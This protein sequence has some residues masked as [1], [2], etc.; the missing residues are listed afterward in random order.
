MWHIKKDTIERWCWCQPLTK[1]GCDKI[2]EV[3]KKLDLKPMAEPGTDAAKDRK[4]KY[5]VIPITDDTRWIFETCSKMVIDMNTQFFEYDLHYISELHFMAYEEK[6]D[7]YNKH[8]DVM[9]DSAGIR[10]LSFS[11]QLSDPETYKGGELL[12]HFDKD[13]VKGKSDQGAMTLYPSFSL[14]E[15]TP[16]VKGV[17]YVLVGW[18]VGPKLK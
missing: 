3:G 15:T 17:S 7:V 5:A 11:I 12:L 1:E 6:G 8:I 4:G 16:L 2:I 9:Y 10:K 13:P 18:V 14:N